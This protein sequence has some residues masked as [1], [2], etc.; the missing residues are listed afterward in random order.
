MD[1]TRHNR[2]QL[3]TN[4]ALKQAFIELLLES[5]EP[6]DITVS[7]IMDRASFN[8]STFYFHYQ[9]K[10]ELIEDLYADARKGSSIP[11]GNRFATRKKF[12]SEART[13]Q[14]PSF[15]SIT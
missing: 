14:R 7:E 4:H 9:N 8:R 2:R 15:C 10:I 5:G 3:G 6:D 13:I 1:T 12:L 11:F